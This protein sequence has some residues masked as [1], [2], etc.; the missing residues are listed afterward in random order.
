MDPKEHSGSRSP[1]PDAGANG[2]N[3]GEVAHTGLTAVDLDVTMVGAS[4]TV[5][6]S[7]GGAGRTLPVV[8]GY[9]V[10]REVGRGGMGVVYEARQVRLNRPCA[11]KMILAGDHAGP[12]AAV[13]FLSEAEAAARLHHE[14][15]VQI[16]NMG[17]HNG[18]P[19]LELEYVEGG[20]LADNASTPRTPTNAARLVEKIAR[21][22]H[23][24]HQQGI[25][26]RDL[27]PANILLTAAGEPKVADFGLAKWLSVDTG[28]TRTES[29]IGSPSYMAPEQAGGHAK[30]VGPAADIYALGAILY[31]LLTGRP[32]FKAATILETLEQVKKVEPPSPSRLQPGLP[33]DLETICL[34]CL[35]KEPRRRYETAEALAEDLR[36]FVAQEPI[37]ARRTG[38]AE[39]TWRWSRRNPVIASLTG[40]VALLLVALAVGATIYAF[41][42]KAI[43]EHETQ[44][45]NDRE[46]FAQEKEEAERKTAAQLYESLVE[47]AR[48]LRLAGKPGYRVRAWDQLHTAIDLNVPERNAN[49]IRDEVIASLGDPIGLPPLDHPAEHIEIFKNSAGFVSPQGRL[50]PEIAGDTVTLRTVDSAPATLRSMMQA[51]GE[52]EQ[53]P[54]VLRSPLGIVHELEFTPDGTLLVGGCE[55][56]LVVWDVASRQTRSVYRGDSVRSLAMHPAGHLAAAMSSLRRIEIWSLTS[57]R[58]VYSTDAGDKANSV[59]FSADGQYLLAM[60]NN[61]VI[62]A[63][64]IA[65]TPEKLSLV[66]HRGGVPGIAFSPDGT[67]LA[68]VS[69]DRTVRIWN[70]QTGELLHT[71]EGHP[72]EVQSVC[73][74]PD[75]R[76]IISADWGAVLRVW[77]SESGAV[78]QQID[79]RSEL[80]R[81]WRVR[82]F[83]DGKS[84]I[85]TGTSGSFIW[86]VDP[87]DGRII[88]SSRRFITASGWDMAVDPTGT[89]VVAALQNQNVVQHNL[90]TNVI[91]YYGINPAWPI[92]C[93]DYSRDGQSI[94]CI[95]PNSTIDRWSIADNNYGMRYNSRPGSR[96]LSVSD[97]DR[98]AATT[99]ASQVSIFDLEADKEL[100]FLPPESSPPWCVAWSP[101]GRRVAVGLSDGGLSIWNLGEVRAC[102]SEFNIELA[103]MADSSSQQ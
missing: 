50:F 92:L 102:L 59:E 86:Q 40:V 4:P 70:T 81:L 17:D 6:V 72:N 98:W 99:V 76:R 24:A 101:D 63:R 55:E 93:L 91:S 16:Y 36:R 57:G 11:L 39:R 41:Q 45:R 74:S 21:G 53:Q 20:N 66:G 52:P 35:Q 60:I 96:F 26:H 67:R 33:R 47:H 78:L 14:N 30:S 18:R 69:K 84:V 5:N 82:V 1:A 46:L 38:Y 37:L 89:C 32:P 2:S 73:F 80:A 77:D 31:E 87:T 19:Y 103:S 90:E 34:K 65:S 95:G 97:N 61:K 27:K 7:S 3:H 43:A 48:A 64:P 54:H 94:F 23:A 75:G 83:P 13:R 71:C 28:L 56:G 88:G 79:A 22:I 100:L 51:F 44:L 49:E 42:Q 29:V 8:P 25:V 68:S 62:F 10:L 58:L 12:E 15:I 9:E 85:A